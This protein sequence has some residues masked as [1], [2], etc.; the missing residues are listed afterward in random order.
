MSHH[1]IKCIPW[2]QFPLATNI[3]S[4]DQI[5]L[6]LLYVTIGLS[7]AFPSYM[8]HDRTRGLDAGSLSMKLQWS[9]IQNRPRPFVYILSKHQKMLRAPAPCLP[10]LRCGS[11]TARNNKT[12]RRKTAR[13]TRRQ[14]ISGLVSLQHL[15]GTEA[16]ERTWAEAAGRK[17]TSRLRDAQL[18]FCELD[19]EG[20]GLRHQVIKT[21]LLIY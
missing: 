10:A 19:E 2:S 17:N 15:A 11:I 1:D 20:G 13:R 14:P 6:L 3:K 7:D 8:A 12:A 16:T 21:G 5:L 9:P 18:W 4:Q